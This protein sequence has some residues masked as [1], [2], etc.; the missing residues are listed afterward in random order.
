M[1]D[2]QQVDSWGSDYYSIVFNIDISKTFYKKKSNRLSTKKTIWKEYSPILSKMEDR[3]E[4]EE[5]QKATEENKYQTITEAM[6][7]AILKAT[8]GKN[9]KNTLKRI[10]KTKSE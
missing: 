1:L 4:T 2:Y 5:Y 10:R 9:E 8:Y 3:L 7:E 6:K